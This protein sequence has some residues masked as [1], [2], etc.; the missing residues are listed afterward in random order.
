MEK[1]GSLIELKP[2]APIDIKEGMR[3][4]DIFEQLKDTGDNYILIGD[5]LT[6]IES[7]GNELNTGGV[8]KI[9]KE[10]IKAGAK[11]KVIRNG[12]EFT[13]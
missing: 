9:S 7:N 6:I 5:M 13:G 4:F 11:Q 8:K 2:Y 3:V 12:K 1:T 10:P